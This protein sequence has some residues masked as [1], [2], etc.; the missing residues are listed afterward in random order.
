M[1][2]EWL[3]IS[4]LWNLGVILIVHGLIGASRYE[5]DWRDRRYWGY[6]AM[7]AIGSSLTLAAIKLLIVQPVG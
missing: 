3:V 2:A 4:F 7:F 5:H 1:S 6:L